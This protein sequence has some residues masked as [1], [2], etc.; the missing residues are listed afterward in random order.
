MMSLDHSVFAGINCPEPCPELFLEYTQICDQKPV[1]SSDLQ[2]DFSAYT[3]FQN[4]P[5]AFRLT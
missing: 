4:S 3:A 5:S 1:F 2:T